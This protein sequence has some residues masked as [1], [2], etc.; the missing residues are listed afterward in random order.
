LVE[1][2]KISSETTLGMKNYLAGIFLISMEIQNTHLYCVMGNP[3][4]APSQ[5]K[6]NTAPYG[7]FLKYYPNLKSMN[8]LKAIFAEMT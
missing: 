8:D 6:F 1:I 4:Q 5:D 7:D 3:L 2:S